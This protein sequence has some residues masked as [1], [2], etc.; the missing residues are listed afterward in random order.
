L[1]EKLFLVKR[2][3]V[4]AGGKVYLKSGK[5]ENSK[6]GGKKRAKRSITG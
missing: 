5:K 3:Q 4:P 6:R 2:R 1:R